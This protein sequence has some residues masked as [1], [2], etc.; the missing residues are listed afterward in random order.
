MKLRVTRRAFT[1]RDRIRRYL[2]R[3]SSHA[4]RTVIP[5]LDEAIDRI[6]HQP[7]VGTQTDVDDVSVMFVGRYPY[8]IFYRVQLDEVQILHIRHTARVPTDLENPA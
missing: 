2:A 7:H 4:A 1:D 6:V 8:K 3:Q 5:R